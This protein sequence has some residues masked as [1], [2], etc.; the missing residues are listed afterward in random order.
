M[1]ENMQIT[2][3]Q[4]M[5]MMGTQETV[6]NDTGFD[7]SIDTD[8]QD[9]ILNTALFQ[10]HNLSISGGGENATFYISGQIP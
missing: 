6:P 9:L 5:I 8:W 3:M 4:Q 1:P 7:P 10:D 2:E